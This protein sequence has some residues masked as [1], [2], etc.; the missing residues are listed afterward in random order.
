MKV[1]RNRSLP[2]AVA[3]ATLG[4]AAASVSCTGPQTSKA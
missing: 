4:M 2:M 3:F 1:S